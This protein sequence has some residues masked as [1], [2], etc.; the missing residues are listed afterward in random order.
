MD[1]IGR[2]DFGSA[3]S[4]MNRFLFFSCRIREPEDPFS[5]SR[6][7]KKKNCS[8]TASLLVLSSTFF[9]LCHTSE[10]SFLR[11]FQTATIGSQFSTPG[12]AVLF[13][14]SFPRHSLSSVLWAAPCAVDHPSQKRKDAIEEAKS[15]EKDAAED[16]VQLVARLRVH[17][18]IVRKT[19]TKTNRATQ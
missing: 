13:R 12:P 15:K 10:S 8:R 5:S 19:C 17:L 6:A 18:G 11:T 1:R 3:S 2:T 16:V 14:R 4:F 9:A 7:Q